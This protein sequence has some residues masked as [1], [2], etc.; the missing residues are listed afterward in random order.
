MKSHIILSAA[1]FASVSCAKVQSKTSSS[2]DS[3][4]GKNNDA[5]RVARCSQVS[6]VE[7]AQIRETLILQVKDDVVSG[8][9]HY[10]IGDRNSLTDT[11]FQHLLGK[12]S[13]TESGT[14]GKV[15][16]KLKDASLTTYFDEDFAPS[17]KIS[18]ISFNI[19]EKKASYLVADDA[20]ATTV[21]QCQ[22]E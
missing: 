9:F 2:P 16:L 6:D 8:T 10:A 7:N 21:G 13:A 15:V 4:P 11:G 18:E 12:I 20:R 22:F 1:L 19:R 5:P 14:D 3:A 17:K